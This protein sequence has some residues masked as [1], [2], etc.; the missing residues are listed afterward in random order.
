MADTF[1]A[2][3]SP[4]R[5][6]ILTLL[7]DRDMTAGEIAQYLDITKPT[8]SGHFNI[9]KDAKLVLTERSG[10]TI[11]YSL[12]LSVAEDLIKSVYALLG[13]KDKN[14]TQPGKTMPKE[15]TPREG[16]V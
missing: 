1:Q 12:N 16:E 14:D 11:T 15:V 5:R 8:L 9:L 4:V 10:T 13:V 3:A 2:L 6:Q 7:R